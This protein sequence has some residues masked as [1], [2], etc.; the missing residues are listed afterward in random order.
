MSCVSFVTLVF[1]NTVFVRRVAIKILAQEKND[2]IKKIIV[3][4]SD[5]IKAVLY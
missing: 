3:R 1:Q 4:N 5:R 2:S